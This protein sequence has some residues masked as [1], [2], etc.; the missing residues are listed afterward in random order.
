MKNIFDDV[1]LRYH[2]IGEN[3]LK[4]IFILKD[5]ILCANSLKNTSYYAKNYGGYNKENMVSIC[6]PISG[7]KV[8]YRAFLVYI[9]EG[10]LSFVLKDVKGTSSS[11]THHDSGFADEEF[12]FGNISPNNIVGIIVNRQLLNKKISELNLLRNMGYGYIN[13]TFLQTV[14]YLKSN[15]MNNIITEEQ[16]QELFNKTDQLI[17]KEFFNFQIKEQIILELSQILSSYLAQF[18]EQKYGI[19]TVV[20]FLQMFN[21]NNLPIYDENGETLDINNIKGTGYGSVKR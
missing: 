17:H 5:G 3:I 14:R 12:H 2:G 15:G 1:T 7:E 8:K 13:N 18:F 11:S 10:G 21:K 6:Y 19:T 4:F 16:M 9:K 20:E